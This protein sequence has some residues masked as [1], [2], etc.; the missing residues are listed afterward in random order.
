MSMMP[1]HDPR[2]PSYREDQNAIWREIR[3]LWQL[4][5][6]SAG[7][8]SNRSPTPAVSSQIGAA[9]HPGTSPEL[10]R[11]DHRHAVLNEVLFSH[12]G[13]PQ[14][15]PSPPYRVLGLQM[16]IIEVHVTAGSAGSTS[17]I[18]NVEVNGTNKVTV[19]LGSNA[20][21]AQVTGLDVAL[22]KGDLVT[23]TVQPGNNASDTVVHVLM[24]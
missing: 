6:K 1:T 10:A 19:V 12:A 14:A 2:P 9:A 7:V 13:P 15:R 22:Q 24:G 23:V 11:S 5:R 17:S 3:A 8:L 21:T 18:F 20:R 4:A 16:T